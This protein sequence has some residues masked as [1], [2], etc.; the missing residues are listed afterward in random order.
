MGRRIREI[1]GTSLVMDAPMADTDLYIEASGAAAVLP[2]IVRRAKS[3]ARVVVVALHREEIGVNFLLVM[4]KELEILGS[5]AQPPDWN[6]MIRMLGDVDL[7]PMITHRFSLDRFA[8]A[9]AIAQDP[10]AGA[11]VIT[12]DQVMEGI[13]EMIHDVQVE[14]TFPDGTK[15]VTIHNPID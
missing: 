13:A 15:L 6:D 2:E 7:S 11:K 1:H 3:G 8:E 14:A 5:I 4:M 9:M 10:E 12:R